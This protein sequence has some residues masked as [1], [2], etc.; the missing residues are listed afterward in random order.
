MSYF[1][2]ITTSA[3]DSS[4]TG[5]QA[6]IKIKMLG[7]QYWW[8]AAGYRT[9]LEVDSMVVTWWIIVAFLGS[10]RM[11]LIVAMQPTLLV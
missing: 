9:F 1:Q 3:D 2:I 7:P 5:T 11:S 4:L 10:V 6:I 8:L